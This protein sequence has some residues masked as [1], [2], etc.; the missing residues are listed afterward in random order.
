M[1]KM[2]LTLL[3]LSFKSQ[4]GEAVLTLLMSFVG[5]HGHT[6]INSAGVVLCRLIWIS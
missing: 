3:V 5:Q 4:H 1:E 2:T 6:D